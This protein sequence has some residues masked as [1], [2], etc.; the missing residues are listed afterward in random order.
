MQRRL[1]LLRNIV[2]R[3]HVRSKVLVR[4]LFSTANL[5]L[6]AIRCKSAPIAPVIQLVIH[7]I[8]DLYRVVPQH[9]QS[10]R[11]RRHVYRL[12]ITVQHQRW[13]LK[14]WAQAR[15]VLRSIQNCGVH[16][17]YSIVLNAHKANL[18]KLTG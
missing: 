8:D 16:V 2:V 5:R 14:R 12:P 1:H 9:D 3:L 10:T 7:W 15:E 11:N 4:E 13:A 17:N 18:Q 6:A